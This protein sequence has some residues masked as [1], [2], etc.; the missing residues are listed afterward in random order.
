MVKHKNIIDFDTSRRSTSVESA[1][2]VPQLVESAQRTAKH[3]LNELLPKFFSQIDNSLFNLADK[4]ESNQQQTLYFDAMREIR[5]QHEL[6]HKIFFSALDSGFKLS[7][8]QAVITPHSDGKLDQ[9]GLV[10]DEQLE[11][12][13]AISNMANA[14]NNIYAQA[15]S[16]IT[17]RLNFLIE[18]TEITKDNS[19]LRPEVLCDA[20]SVAAGCMNTEIKVRLVVY[21]LFDKVVIQQLGDMYDTINADFI[22][23]GVLPRIKSTIKKSDSQTYPDRQTPNTDLRNDASPKVNHSSPK[24]KQTATMN[25]A[26]DVFSTIQQLLSKQREGLEA[27]LV[28]DSPIANADSNA[29][30]RNRISYSPEDIVSA[31]SQLQIGAELALLKNQNQESSNIIKTTVMKEIGKI[32]GRTV[33][34]QIAQADI[35]SIDIVSRL[36]DF[37]LDDPTLSDCLKVQIV[38]LQI[39]VLKVAILDNE[40]FS[41]KSHP[42]RQ[43]L[44]ELAYA[45]SGLN[46]ENPEEDSTLKMVSYVV[47]QILEEFEDN[48]SIFEILLSEFTSFMENE[49]E[50]NKLTEDMLEGA[51]NAAVREI[52]LK[53]EN[54]NFPPL[55]NTIFLD[56][57]KDVLIH[58]YLRDGVKS[59]A[60]ETAVQV[61]DDLIWSVEPK[62]I[63]SERNRLIKVIPSILNGLRDGFTLINF[64]MKK[65]EYLFD[66][67]E[68]LHLASLRGGIPETSTEQKPQSMQQVNTLIHYEDSD[69]LMEDDFGIDLSNFPETPSTIDQQFDPYTAE[70]ITSSEDNDDVLFSLHAESISEMALGTWVEFINPGSNVRSRGKLAWKCD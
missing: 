13:L 49:K 25:A 54:H 69:S 65:S 6:M 55:V 17:A 20:F 27:G 36:F 52:Q 51:K 43:L 4:A 61:A 68:N 39:P 22:A 42:A 44:N 50:S 60:W 12:S 37:I 11:E 46:E 35:D 18:K 41:K 2:P 23:A 56:A 48:P 53:V 7:L 5:L 3:Y 24:E 67:L 15:L 34:K 62:L 64:D 63:V 19:P 8:S 40:F 33:G 45:S 31:L 9:V 70:I 57:W 16:D 38:R 10:E 21:K 26:D 32:Q 47:D 66:Q 59:N 28:I 29:E 30:S 14:A 1:V 58:L